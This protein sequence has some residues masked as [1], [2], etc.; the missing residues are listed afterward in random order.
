MFDLEK[1]NELAKKKEKEN[2]KFFAR[3]KVKRPGNL[4]VVVRELHNEVFSA[5][6]CTNCANCCKTLG[7]R[8]TET[9]IDRLSK[10]LNLKTDKFIATYLRVDEDRDYIFK[11]MPCPFLLPDNYCSVYEV[12]PKACRDYPHTN[13]RKFHQLYSLLHLKNSYTCPA[14]L[15]IIE[16][17][18]KYYR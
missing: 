11:T 1:I 4:D 9:D 10:F 6:Q 13:R 3:L 5:I 8:I 7:P 17:L 18:K 16:G 2:R 12:R 15:E 14:V